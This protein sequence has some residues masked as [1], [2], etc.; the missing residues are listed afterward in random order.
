MPKYVNRA[1]PKKFE[2]LVH[3]PLQVNLVPKYTPLV[4]REIEIPLNHCPHA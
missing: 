3:L 4:P 2:Y 1:Q